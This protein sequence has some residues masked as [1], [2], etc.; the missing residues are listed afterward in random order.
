V[1]AMNMTSIA[2]YAA[3]A[4]KASNLDAPKNTIKTLKRIMNTL[5]TMSCIS[6]INAKSVALAVTVIISPRAFTIHVATRRNRIRRNRMTPV[7]TECIFVSEICS[8]LG[9]DTSQF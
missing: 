9:L 2:A 3:V 5:M 8:S 1:G 4:V 7:T 6:V